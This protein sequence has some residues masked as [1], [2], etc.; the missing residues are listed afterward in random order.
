[1]FNVV[2]ASALGVLL[3][4]GNGTALEVCIGLGVL[5]I[6]SQAVVSAKAP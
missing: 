2:L 6:T 1:M 4:T 3:N 5:S